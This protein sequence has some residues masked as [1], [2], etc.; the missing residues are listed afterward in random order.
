MSTCHRTWRFLTV[1][2]SPLFVRILNQTNPFHTPIF[3]LKVHFNFILL[4][5]PRLSKLPHSIKFTNQR[6]VSNSLQIR[7]PHLLPNVI[8]DFILINFSLL[9]KKQL[10]DSLI[11]RQKFL[12]DVFNIR[13][14]MRIIH[15]QSLILVVC[16][17]KLLKK[18]WAGSVNS[19]SNHVT[20]T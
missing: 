10:H 15:F 1:L 9:I 11:L 20:A 8:L 4:N 5:T 14:T 2:D 7:R 17:R 13:C 12:F 19:L 16:L 3:S 6:P 18:F